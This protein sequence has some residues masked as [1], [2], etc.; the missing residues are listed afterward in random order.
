[1]TRERQSNFRIPGDASQVIEKI[2]ASFI[3]EKRRSRSKAMD[4][5]QSR[6]LANAVVLMDAG[7]ID[8]E[9]LLGKV[10][11]L[12]KTTTQKERSGF[13]GMDKLEAFMQSLDKTPIAASEPMAAPVVPGDNDEDEEPPEEDEDAEAEEIEEDAGTP[14]ES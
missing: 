9:K 5:L 6:L 11:D 2:A 1:M 8:F 13:D 14:I 10:G 3:Q 4:N 12:E 7:Y